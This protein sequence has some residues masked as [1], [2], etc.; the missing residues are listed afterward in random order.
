MQGCKGICDSFTNILTN[1]KDG[2]WDKPDASMCAV[3]CIHLTT[4]DV[5]C[6]CCKTILR[7][8][9]HSKRAKERMKCHK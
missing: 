3:C 7:K 9:P 4:K 1:M 6:S 8:G 2:V 5:F